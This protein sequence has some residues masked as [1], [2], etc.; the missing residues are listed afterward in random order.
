MERRGRLLTAITDFNGDC[1]GCLSNSTAN[2]Y[3]TISKVCA[4]AVTTSGNLEDCE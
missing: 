1:Y 2:Y 4:D 3:C